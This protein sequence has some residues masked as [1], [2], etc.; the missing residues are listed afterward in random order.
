[1]ISTQVFV[2]KIIKL[3]FF[4]AV[5]KAFHKQNFS[6]I[7]DVFDTNLLSIIKKV[8]LKQKCFSDQGNFSP[9][10]FFSWSWKFSTNKFF[11]LIKEIFHKKG[12]FHDQGIFPQ[13]KIFFMIKEIFHKQRSFPQAKIVPWLK[14]PSIVKDQKCFLKAK[15]LDPFNTKSY[16]KL[17]C[18]LVTKDHRYLLWQQTF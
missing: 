4:S 15:I 1:M 18:L 7:K 2:F 10:F 5:K 12:S 17:Y 13:T 6:W 3:S 16:T 11:S 14:K 8:F 9:K